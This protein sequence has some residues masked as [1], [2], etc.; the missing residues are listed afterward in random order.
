VRSEGS[1]WEDIAE[2]RLSASGLRTLA[3][4]WHCRHGELDLVMRDG[5]SVVF[6]EVRY[7]GGG[8]FGGGIESVHAGKQRRLIAAASLFLQS[9]PALARLPCRFDVVALG[10]RREDPDWEW[11]RG[12]FEVS[13]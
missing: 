4:N 12:A 8:R 13:A 1:A 7:R 3:R 2:K 11:L 10:G 6:V 5:D 9:Q